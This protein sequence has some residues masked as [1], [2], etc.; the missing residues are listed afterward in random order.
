MNQR[1][2][3]WI[4]ILLPVVAFAQLFPNLG[5]QR[6]GISAYTFLKM[7]VSPRSSGMG[8][9]SL[10]QSGDGYS[11][12]VNPAGLSE[13][14]GTSVGVAHTF[15]AAGINQTYASISRPFKLGHF[16]VSMNY[17]GSG[18]MPVRTEFEPDGTGQLFYAYYSSLGLTYS[19]QLTDHFHYGVSLHWVHEQLAQLSANTATIDLGFL[20]RTGFKDLSFGVNVQNFGFN[21]KLKG[22]WEIDTSFYHR[23]ITLDNYPPPTVFQLGVSMIP[24]KTES[25]HLTVSVQLNHPNDN[26]ENIR[27]GAEYAYRNLLFA[28]IGYKINVKDQPFPTLGFGLRTRIGKHP[29]HFD[30][31]FEPMQYLGS[32][33]KVGLSVQINDKNR[34]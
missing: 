18:A 32:I 10:C 23:P 7:D 1:Y 6:A 26:A 14:K 34:E 15:W 8:G 30:Y 12:F 13:V 2:I 27:L 11:I 29:L 22:A 3:F 21:S 16:G 9:A 20:Y 33:H 31:A 5:G 4:F 17:L 28:R 24:Y 25:Q 19:K